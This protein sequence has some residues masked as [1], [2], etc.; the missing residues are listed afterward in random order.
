[1]PIAVIK[2]VREYDSGEIVEPGVYMDVK[3][4]AIVT[5]YDRDVLPEEAKIVRKARRF[6]RLEVF[7]NQ[8]AV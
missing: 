2:R 6:R 3:S 7:E 8:N 5:I 4:G 1:M